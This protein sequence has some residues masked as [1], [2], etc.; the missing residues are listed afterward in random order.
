LI[1]LAPWFI[2]KSKMVLRGTYGNYAVSIDIVQDY[3]SE[4][5]TNAGKSKAKP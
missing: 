4:D 2:N 1:L 5:L 3:F